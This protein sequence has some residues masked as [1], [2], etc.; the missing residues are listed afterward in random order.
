MR[1]K[2]YTLPLTALTVLALAACS[3]TGDKPNVSNLDAAAAKAAAQGGEAPLPASIASLEK[4]YLK[5]TSDAAAATKY[6]AA[7][8][9]GDY[10]NKAAVVL[11]PFANNA[12]SPAS[13]KTEFAAIQLALGNSERAEKYARRATSQDPKDAKAQHYLGIALDAQGKQPE[14]EAA[15]R[16]ALD[17]WKGDPTALMNN[18]A[19]NLSAQ[20]YLDEASEILEKALST[21]P[22]RKEVERNLRIINA[23]RQSAD[24]TTPT[25]PR[26]PKKI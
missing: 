16:K 5:N 23:L 12:K 17:M 24:P 18:L 9:E 19:L 1:T 13:A 15:Y 11:E 20:G 26:K 22:N 2:I 25:P 3:T 7:L 4:I 10:A 14:A 6:A 21:A 8:R